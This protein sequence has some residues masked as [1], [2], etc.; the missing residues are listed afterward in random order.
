MASD[1]SQESTVRDYYK[2]L[3]PGVMS[4][5]VFTAIAG[6]ALADGDKNPY[7]MAIILLA[8]SLSSGGA[9]ALNMWYDADIDKIMK[10]NPNPPFTSW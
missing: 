1:R 5:I 6:F 7:L 2:L 4:L 3:K 8:I 10:K 9:A